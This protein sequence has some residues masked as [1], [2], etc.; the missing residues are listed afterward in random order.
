MRPAEEVSESL[1]DSRLRRFGA[2]HIHLL[3]LMPRLVTLLFASLVLPFASSAWAQPVI[4][5]TIVPPGS[6]IDDALIVGPDGALYG[7]RWGA[8]DAQPGRTT[9]RVDLSDFSTSTYV[10]NLTH[11][12]GLAFDTEGNLY[13]ANFGEAIL[14]RIAPDGTRTTYATATSGN[15]SGVLIHP[16]T[17]VVYVTNYVNDTVGIATGDSSIAPFLS[18]DG[19][20]PELN[21]PVG[22]AVDDSGH[23]YVSNF[24]D[25]KIF[26]VAE[27]GDLTEIADLDGQPNATTGFIAYANGHLYATSFSRNVIEE[28]SLA[29]GTVRILAGT[30]TAGSADGPGNRAQFNAPNGIAAS[31]TGDTLYVSDASPRSV[32]R[33]ILNRATNTEADIPDATILRLDVYPNPSDGQAEVRLHLPERGALRLAVFDVLGREVEVLHEGP[34]EAGVHR[35][36]FDATRLPAGNYLVHLT[37]PSGAQAVRLTLL[38]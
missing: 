30:G 5:D 34:A 25:G 38:R 28:V 21:G 14:E 1:R 7:S 35:L 9:T 23:L 3:P 29:D 19:I 17:G 37:T 8:F 4:V 2:F 13:V 32:R 18:N 33:I 11:S 15:L 20:P 10:D 36:G 26:R 31:V 27:S 12:N 22:M 16:T 24:N 6:A